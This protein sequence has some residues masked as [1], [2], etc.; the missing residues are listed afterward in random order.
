M[1]KQDLAVFREAQ[2]PGCIFGR[3]V[4]MWAHTQVNFV[5]LVS[6]LIKKINKQLFRMSKKPEDITSPYTWS[7][8]SCL[9]PQLGPDLIHSTLPE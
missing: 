6:K 3:L 4:P 9:M 1:D 7:N 5:L 8:L 2:H